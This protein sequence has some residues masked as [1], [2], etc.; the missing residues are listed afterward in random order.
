[1]EQLSEDLSQAVESANNLCF[2]LNDM[3]TF[4]SCKKAMSMAFSFA[5]N[6]LQ[7][8]CSAFVARTQEAGR[9]R[10]ELERQKAVDT[11]QE[12][13]KQVDASEQLHIAQ[14]KKDLDNKSED[15]SQMKLQISGLEQQNATLSLEIKRL[16]GVATVYKPVPVKQPLT[17]TPSPKVPVASVMEEMEKKE[18]MEE[19]EEEEWK[20]VEEEEEDDDF[21][22]AR[23]SV[24]Y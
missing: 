17:V 9:L 19:E 21:C 18:E 2:M 20:G 5:Q 24:D 7:N 15:I 8:M 13:A 4:L 12:V 14:L 6:G 1:M 23:V 22:K 16:G 3:E 11:Q 10:D